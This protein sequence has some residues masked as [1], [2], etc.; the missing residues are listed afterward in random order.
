MVSSQI[1]FGKTTNAKN[2]NAICPHEKTVHGREETRILYG[3]IRLSILALLSVISRRSK[4]TVAKFRLVEKCKTKEAQLNTGSVAYKS[5]G[6]QLNVARRNLSMPNEATA[7]LRAAVSVQTDLTIPS[8]PPR[9]PAGRHPP[10]APP[11]DSR[12]R[13]STQPADSAAPAARP[14]PTA[15]AGVARAA[16][17]GGRWSSGSN[18]RPKGAVW[19]FQISVY[20]TLIIIAKRKL[21]N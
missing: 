16:R 14:F 9:F 3:N 5:T 12:W 13:Q 15:A 6:I 8:I 4:L 1:T 2:S 7:Q 11:L 10:A 20:D 19:F 21:C 18:E 17:A